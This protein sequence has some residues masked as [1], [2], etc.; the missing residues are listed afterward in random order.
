MHIFLSCFLFCFTSAQYELTENSHGR[1]RDQSWDLM[2]NRQCLPL[3]QETIYFTFYGNYL[4]IIIIAQSFNCV[5][6]MINNVVGIIE[7]MF[8][9]ALF[10]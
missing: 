6:I 4:N 3:S 2:I 9:K 7:V 10:Q 1:A 8:A 5:E